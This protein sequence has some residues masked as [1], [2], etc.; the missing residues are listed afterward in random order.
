MDAE[1]EGRIEQNSAQ[2]HSVLDELAST[3]A[4]NKSEIETDINQLGAKVDLMDREIS[5]V[6]DN[7]KENDNQRERQQ[8]ENVEHIDHRTKENKV[9][10]ERQLDRLQS[11]IKALRSQMS[12]RESVRYAD[13]CDVGHAVQQSPVASVLVEN[14]SQSDQVTINTC[15]CRPS[16]CNVCVKDG[17]N[18]HNV[19]VPVG[20]S[21]GSS[22]LNNSEFSLPLFDEN[23]D[24]NPVYHLRQLDEYLKLK[25]VPADCH[26]AVSYRSLTGTLSRQWAEAV[27]HQLRDYGAFREAFLNT[28]WSPSRQSLVN[29]SLYQGRYDRQSGLSLS[30]HFLKYATMASYLEPR[31]TDVEVIEAIR[32]HFPISVQRAMLNTQLKSI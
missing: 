15:A 19:T 26:L 9:E 32:Y 8:R 24:I 12:E 22:Y 25:R 2:T 4:T 16:S 6:K 18:E 13:T 28:W 14:S 11:E 17:M 5:K 30:A 29:C 21:T 23:S 7:L 27:S 10:A 3:I 20:Q 31:P 1:I